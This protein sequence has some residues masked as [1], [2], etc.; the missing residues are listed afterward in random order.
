[1]RV[2]RGQEVGQG[3]RMP[4][5]TP[6]DFSDTA[7]QAADVAAALAA[8]RGATVRLI[9]SV[10]PW[11]ASSEAAAAVALD[12][13][14]SQQLE[15]EADRLRAAGASV[16]PVVR[17]G[18]AG[19]EVIAAVGEGSIEAIVLG[20]GDPAAGHH[21]GG[22]VAERVAEAAPV[23]TLVVRR[24][25][26]LQAWLAGKSAL[27]VLCAVD[28]SRTSN[29]ALAVLKSWADLGA[30]EIE[31]VHFARPD[32]VGT[33]GDGVFS[34]ERRTAIQRD[35]WQRLRDRFGDG[36][37]MT[38][39]VLPDD[40]HAP[41]AMARLA[42]ESGADLLVIGTRQAHGLK[43]LFSTS[44]SRGVLTHTS[45]NV[46]C[47][48]LAAAPPETPD[49]P[50]FRRILV[51]ASLAAEDTRILR[52]ACHLAEAPG[53][54]VHIVHVCPV[55]LPSPNP[56]YI[57]ETGLEAGLEAEQ[58]RE[59]A[60]ARLAALQASAGLPAG[61]SVTTEAVIDSNPGSALSEAAGR[62]GADV[63]C[64]GSRGQSRL[65]AVLL[66]SVAQAVIAQAH[67]PV[68]VVPP[69]RE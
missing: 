2:V 23:P 26:P 10:S 13:V 51:A 52:Y 29:A 57:A 66:G 24:A 47:V 68:L 44:F 48:P 53:S 21:F 65:G 62:F 8:K 39:H 30:L 43:R 14:A 1:M 54:A 12:E 63:I 7:R 49:V 45:A 41:E 32:D 11:I 25:A 40:G 6:T 60:E 42:A 16:E 46:L 19:G 27:R 20:S 17:R 64:M 3:A 33:P 4:I 15:A 37:R 9:H 34:D 28:F 69:P 61:A 22:S 55:P 38:I 5:L 58:M 31:A 67:R 59:A 18:T 35:V 50:A 56:I 36:R